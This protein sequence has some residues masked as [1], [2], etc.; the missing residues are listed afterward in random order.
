MI[1]R[2]FSHARFAVLVWKEMETEIA[3]RAVFLVFVKFLLHIPS[4]RVLS[5][6]NGGHPSKTTSLDQFKSQT[7]ICHWSCCCS[8]RFLLGWIYSSVFKTNKG[9]MMERKVR[10][11]ENHLQINV[12]TPSPPLVQIRRRGS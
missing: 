5:E 6:P 7:E 10:R 8:P 3:S 2:Q 9:T 12:E 4:S 11:S 1:Q